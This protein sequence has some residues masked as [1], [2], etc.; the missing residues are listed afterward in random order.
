MSG[1]PHSIGLVS[2]RGG[3]EPG[4]ISQGCLTVRD[5]RHCAWQSETSSRPLFSFAATGISDAPLA[6]C[7][8]GHSTQ[9]LSS[10]ASV[11]TSRPGHHNHLAVTAAS[12]RTQI[13]ALSRPAQ[14]GEQP[15]PMRKHLGSKMCSWS[16]HGSNH[17]LFSPSG[18]SRATLVIPRGSWWSSDRGFPYPRLTPELDGFVVRSMPPD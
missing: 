6:G 4:A 14:G 10:W 3:E 17:S 13:L 7:G 11:T 2:R 8:T 16:A 5:G 1:I 15:I 18:S 12:G 9:G